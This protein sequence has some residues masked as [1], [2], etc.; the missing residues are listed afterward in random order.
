MN[1]SFLLSVQ[2]NKAEAFFGLPTVEHLSSGRIFWEELEADKLDIVDQKGNEKRK[3]GT[4][5]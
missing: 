4:C 3:C 1:F 5:T 2:F